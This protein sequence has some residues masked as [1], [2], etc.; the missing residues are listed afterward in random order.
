MKKKLLSICLSIIMLFTMTPVAAFADDGGGTQTATEVPEAV[1][2]ESVLGQEPVITS[3]VYEVQDDVNVYTVAADVTVYPLEATVSADDLIAADSSASVSFYGKDKTLSD[4]TTEAVIL[5]PG[6]GTTVY[7]KVFSPGTVSEARYAFTVRLALSTDAQQ[8]DSVIKVTASDAADRYYP[9]INGDIADEINELTDPVITLLENYSFTPAYTGIGSKGEYTRSYITFSSDLTLDLNGK[10]LTLTNGYLQMRSSSSVKNGTVI[11]S[12]T[13]QDK[14][15]YGIYV[16][17]GDFCA[18][19]DCAIIADD[20]TKGTA[21]HEE[22]YVSAV[23]RINSTEAVLDNVTV[24]NKYT[25]D[26]DM[27]SRVTGLWMESQHFTINGG[28]FTGG[29]RAG[30]LNL[31][32]SGKTG[33]VSGA[34]F[35]ATGAGICAVDTYNYGTLTFQGESVFK[36]DV[37]QSL[38]G[39]APVILSNVYISGSLTGL[40]ATERTVQESV[41]KDGIEYTYYKSL[42]EHT[43]TIL[44]TGDS[45]GASVSPSDVVTVYETKSSV[46]QVKLID[47]YKLTGAVYQEAGGEPVDITS[48]IVWDGLTG[49]YTVANNPASDYTITFTVEEDFGEDIVASIGIT[50]YRSLSVALNDLQPDDTLKLLSDSFR[51]TPLLFTENAVIDL[52]GYTL[53]MNCADTQAVEVNGAVLTLED[54]SAQANGKID[55]AYSDGQNNFYGIKL[56]GVNAELILNSGAICTKL[57]GLCVQAGAGQKITVNGGRLTAADGSAISANSTAQVTINGGTIEN[58]GDEAYAVI[59]LAHMASLDMSGGSVSSNSTKEGCIISA[60]QS[61]FL[62]YGKISISGGTVTGKNS[63]ALYIFQSGSGSADITGGIL[64]AENSPAIEAIPTA[65]STYQ[66]NI[67]DGA[68]LDAADYIYET[69]KTL[70]DSTDFPKA[71]ISGGAF[72]YGEIPWSDSE[73]VSFTDDA[74]GKAR[75]LSITADSEGDYAGWYR[76]VTTESLKWT[77]ANDYPRTYQEFED[78]NAMITTASETYGDGTGSGFNQDLWS[79]F[80]NAYEMAVKVSGYVLSDD[81][82][83]NTNSIKSANQNEIDYR[84]AELGAALTALEQGMTQEEFD[85]LPDG[86]YSI[87]VDMYKAGTSVLSMA[88]D[89]IEH[90]A[91]LTLQDGTGTLE[92]KFHPMPRVGLMGHLEKI[93]IYQGDTPEQAKV[94]SYNHIQR[95]EGAYSNYYY[96]TMD[97]SDNMTPEDYA[98]AYAAGNTA[99]KPYLPGKVKFSMPYL[100]TTGD[101]NRIYARVLVDAMGDVDQDVIVYLKYSTLKPIET[102]ATLSLNTNNVSLI[103]GNAIAASQTVKAKL[104]KA[105]GY[106]LRWE[107]SDSGVANVTPGVDSTAVISGV[108]AGTCTVTVTAS[109]AGEYDLVKT[110]DVTVAAGTAEP[111]KVEGVTTN[112]GTSMVTLSGN[113]LVTA[114]QDENH[115]DVSSSD[116]IIN[117][118]SGETNITA[119]TVQIPA[120]VASVLSSGR[121]VTIKTDMGDVTLNAAALSQIKQAGRAV[122]LTVSAADTPA[123]S[124]GTFTAAYSLTLNDAN[125][126]AIPFSNGTATISVPCDDARVKYAYHIENGNRTERQPVTI[127]NGTASFNTTHF[128]TWALSENQYELSGGD[129]PNNQN[130]G[131]GGAGSGDNEFF[132]T[133]GNYYVDIDLW[134][135]AGDEVSMGNVAFKNNDRALVTVQDEKITTVQV[136]TNPVDVDQYHS[137]ITSFKVGGKSVS[138]LETGTVTTEPAGK[139]YDYIK[140][141]SFNMPD[142]GQPDIKDAVTYV[143][144]EFKVPDTPMDAAVGDTLEARLKFTWKSTK[145]TTDTSLESDDSTAKGKSSL[146]GDDIEDVKLTDTVTGIKLTTDTERVSDEAKLSVAQITS[147]SEFRNTEKAMK[148]ITD[149]WSL[150]KIIVTEDGKETAPQGSVTLSFPC[151]NDGLT[152]YRISDG[153]TKTILKGEVKKGYYVVSSSSLGL[154]AIVGELA[155]AP[156]ETVGKFT[157]VTESYWASA[158]IAAAVDKELFTGVTDTTFNPEGQMTRAMLFTVLH[159]MSGKAGETTGELWYSAAMEWAKSEGISDGTN[160]NE[161]ITR[162]ELAAMLYRYAGS[163]AVTGEL[164]AFN[165]ADL[166]SPWAVAA[167]KWAVDQG[168]LTGKS[169][170]L[171]DPA[172]PATRAQ[173]AAMLVRYL[174]KKA[175]ETAK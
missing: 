129:D 64:T 83:S 135:A 114:G 162:E 131:E 21:A 133:D 97:A 155:E 101:G 156:A 28:S 85:N 109:K 5:K 89:A 67:S 174:D 47:D 2:M 137:A 60:A 10:T 6:A 62:T 81:T 136:A 152:V 45:V 36:G 134:K 104:K 55:C 151:G 120:G 46:Y 22:N 50:E 73:Y 84:E 119:A 18:F 26:D 79:V 170:D 105:D 41:T 44:L 115:V 48:S 56:E 93:W 8:D 113:A 12:N 33:V 71:Q 72:K 19:E 102:E 23:L 121:N 27:S 78:L 125:G 35:T 11:V 140:R 166:L 68:K 160:P 32:S 63:P 61:G 53:T 112:D 107:T 117:A 123:S 20:N 154:F 7:A 143:D 108:G 13:T 15:N 147:G 90:T 122:T 30:Y 94:N 130:P 96:D 100:I 3:S 74:A 173:V 111:V 175:G 91:V 145:D 38:Q 52:N 159:R 126:T 24:T 168:I 25:T 158:Y 37:V 98:A 149:S 106:S 40:Y 88:N 69:D 17:S 127:S 150:Y 92:M 75:V 172:G 99:Y 141:A 139:K 95:V 70:D 110:I 146:T 14:M 86:T 148:G 82:V 103:E 59:S 138:T 42:P 34:A 167:M 16:K 4:T 116:I 128:S 31:N 58:T 124:V 77:D 165:D 57:R 49:S 132:L 66:I 51:Q 153:G 157:D 76:P 80:K 1:M 163:P 142:S 9:A 39:S 65:G 54:T 43:A 169:S 144:V 29:Y 164:A 171:L 161:N 87:E 118:S